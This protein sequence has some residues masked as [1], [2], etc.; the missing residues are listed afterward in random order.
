MTP[1]VRRLLGANIIAFF[2]QQTVPSVTAAL[3]FVPMAVLLRPWTIVTYM[4]LHAG[5]MHILFNMLGLFFFGPRVEARIGSR[6]FITLYLLAGVSGALLSFVFAPYSP[7]IGASAAVL[8]VMLAY[9][10]YWPRDQVYIWGV[11]PVQIR[12]LVLITTVLALWS[13]FGGSRGGVADFAHLGGFAGA[14]LYVKW[15]ARRPGMARFERQLVKQT[16]VV[17]LANWKRV[18]RDKVHEVNRAEVD[19]ILDK[20]SV[21]GLAS[22]TPQERTF[23]TH[24]V[25]K[26]ETQA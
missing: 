3:D 21:T 25:P 2:L 14:F 24:F 9:A 22:L 6:R 26:D 16:P 23:L 18:N 13:G 7:I 1:W 11:V 10:M 4:F 15:I 5:I 8:G 20:I 19:R 17:E 12:W